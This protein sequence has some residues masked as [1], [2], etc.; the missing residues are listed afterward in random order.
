[1][2]PHVG[3][4]CPRESLLLEVTML[5]A[6][7]HD[8]VVRP[9]WSLDDSVGPVVDASGALGVGGA[10]VLVALAAE[11]LAPVLPTRA[12]SLTV[13]VVPRLLLEG[14]VLAT[15]DRYRRVRVD[16]LDLRI[17][18]QIAV[19]RAEVVE[20]VFL[21]LLLGA[22]HD[23]AGRAALPVHVVRRLLHEE[24]RAGLAPDRY[25]DLAA[26]PTRAGLRLGVIQVRVL[27]VD[28]VR[29]VRAFRYEDVEGEFVRLI[30]S[31]H[32]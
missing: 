22:Q 32:D 11:G 24:D 9:L 13:A 15:D 29:Q 6:V 25:L 26:V 28:G 30:G 23:T 3:Q 16:V 27:R 4:P 7:Q 10:V 14:S 19:R 2:A 18:V 17:V 8:G 1:L 5:G 21:A 31:C 20:R 12:A